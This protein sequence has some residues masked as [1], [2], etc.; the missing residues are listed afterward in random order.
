MF[1]KIYIEGKNAK[2][3]TEFAKLFTCNNPIHD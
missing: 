1:G 2:G 3:V